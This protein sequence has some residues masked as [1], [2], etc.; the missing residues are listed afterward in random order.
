MVK[1]QGSPVSRYV[2]CPSAWVVPGAAYPLPSQQPYA[3]A[4]QTHESVLQLLLL[5]LSLTTPQL[6]LKTKKNKLY[7]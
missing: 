6:H 5:P 2:H 7:T 1:A 3:R 4:N